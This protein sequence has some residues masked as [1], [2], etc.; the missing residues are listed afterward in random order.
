[1]ALKQCCS[2]SLVRCKMASRD[3]ADAGVRA[4]AKATKS[5]AFLAAHMD[6]SSGPR[7]QDSFEPPL[8]NSNVLVRPL[9]QPWQRA[10]PDCPALEPSDPPGLHPLQKKL[11]DLTYQPWQL[12]AT[13][14]IMPEVR[15]EQHVLDMSQQAFG[16][17]AASNISR[18]LRL[19]ICAMTHMAKV[20]VV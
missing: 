9:L 13:E 19:R 10:L 18:S 6:F 17:S 7:P 11:S 20:Q 8:D 16:Y 1:M 5:A 14:P 2:F 12:E 3:H 4:S 15:H